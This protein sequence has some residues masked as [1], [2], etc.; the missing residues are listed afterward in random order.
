MPETSSSSY[1]DS[2]ISQLRY[3]EIRDLQPLSYLAMSTWRMP[4]VIHTKLDH[5][6][7]VTYNTKTTTKHM[8]V[9][10]TQGETNSKKK[11]KKKRAR[12]L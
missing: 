6:K 11:R 5:K 2:Y 12:Q 7:S 8:R 9:K 3:K 4:F 1:I 10:Q